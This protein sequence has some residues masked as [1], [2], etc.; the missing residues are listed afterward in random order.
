[1]ADKYIVRDRTMKYEVTEVREYF[2][3]VQART[4]L[5]PDPVPF[6]AC[7]STWNGMPDTIMALSAMEI[8]SAEQKSTA[9]GLL[10]GH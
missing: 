7:R 3:Y 9:D 2:L 1:M 5:N 4:P 8:V 10:Q 6:L